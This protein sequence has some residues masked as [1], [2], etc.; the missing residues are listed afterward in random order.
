MQKN[1]TILRL[2]KVLLTDK[3][4]MPNGLLQLLKKDIGSVL[5]GYFDISKDTLKIEID[6]NTEGM[7]D[8]SLS[9]KAERIKSPKFIK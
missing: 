2:K 7:Y 5:N 1:N 8:I 9:A 6:S 4:N 3:I